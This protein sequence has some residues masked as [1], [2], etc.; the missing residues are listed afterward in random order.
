MVCD[1]S[2]KGITSCDKKAVY[3]ND[4]TLVTSDRTMIS[5]IKG[6]KRKGVLENDEAQVF[7]TEYKIIDVKGDGN[8]LFRS[9]SKCLYG[10]EERHLEIRRRI[11]SYVEFNWDLEGDKFSYEN[12]REYVDY[13]GRPSTYGTD[14]EISIFVKVYKVNVHLCQ[15]KDERMLKMKGITMLKKDDFTDILFGC[16]DDLFI[17]GK[18]FYI[19]FSGL[20]QGGHFQ[21]LETVSRCRERKVSIETHNDMSLANNSRNCKKYDKIRD[22]RIV[23][24][25][26]KSI[27]RCTKTIKGNEKIEMSKNLRSNSNSEK[28]KTKKQKL[29]EIDQCGK[30]GGKYQ[31]SPRK[32]RRKR[33]SK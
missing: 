8:C 22:Q 10:T 17:K 7:S 1:D 2:C 25:C 15:L 18:D 11:V 16:F 24:K 13:M 3:S 20:L 29:Y 23:E 27:R 21:I 19:L 31:Q 28:L 12:A 5:S 32:Q 14:F 9:F 30:K 4:E 33:G 6:E 26:R